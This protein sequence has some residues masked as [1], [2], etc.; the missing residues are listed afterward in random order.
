MKKRIQ[1]SIA[2]LGAAVLTMGLAGCSSSSNTPA[3][4]APAA[5]TAEA[6]AA[7]VQAESAADTQAAEA[8]AGLSGSITLAGSTSMEKFAN[9]LAEAFMEKYPDVTVQAEF[10]GSS[11]GVEAVLGGQSDVGNSSRKLKDEEKEKGA[12]E[13]IVAIDG[14]A[15]VT[16]PANTAADLTKEQLI[17]IYN[18]T[19]TNWKDAGGA[20]Q[21]IVVIGREA[22]SG[23]RGAFEEILKLEDACKYANE[24]DS[25]GAVMAKVAS[26]PGAIGYVS[27]DVI[28]DTVKL[29]TLNGVEANEEN[30]KTGDYFLS[31]PFVMATNGEIS[32]QND[33]VK[34]LFD[35]VYSA[36]GDELVK[37]VGLITTK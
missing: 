8:A 9:A 16:D 22:G 3:S 15:V 11:A 29:L 14:I 25:T 24:L 5:D 17:N 19:I 28:D 32:A 27:L 26:T 37:S 30:I 1:K 12:V 31:R 7:D 35:Y 20:D 36:E 23:T 10:T 34:A 4:S 18:G 33:L 13:N 2:I 6:P 21:P